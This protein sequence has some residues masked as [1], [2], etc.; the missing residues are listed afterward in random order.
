MD[1]GLTLS[2]NR[3]NASRAFSLFG[4]KVQ[5]DLDVVDRFPKEDLMERLGVCLA[6]GEVD[7]SAFEALDELFDPVTVETDVIDTAGVS[8]LVGNPL[9]Y[10]GVWGGEVFLL[11]V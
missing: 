1:T 11:V 9:P 2:G 7:L 3:G 10:S 8:H 6:F 5:F 4:R